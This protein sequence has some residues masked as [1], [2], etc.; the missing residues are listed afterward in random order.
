[1]TKIALA[2][3][4]GDNALDDG[5]ERMIESV[6]DEVQG[7][8]VSF[9]GT[10]MD[11]V[12]EMD[13]I[14]DSHEGFVEAA[15]V[16]VPWTDD[17]SVARNHSFSLVAEAATDFDWILWL[18]CDDV[19]D[20]STY[21][22]NLLDIIE[23]ANEKKLHGVFLD[24]VY[25][26]DAERGVVLASHYKDRLFRADARFEWEYP[27]HENCVGPFSTRMG[28]VFGVRV[29][30]LRGE[31]EP[32]RDRNRRIVKKWYEEA[33]EHEP[34]A[35]MYMGYETFAMAEEAEGERDKELLYASAIK[36]F[37]QFLSMVGAGDDAYAVELM[38]AEA[39]RNLG[40]MNFALDVALQCVKME[41]T[42]NAAYLS[43]AE[44]HITAGNPSEG[45]I[46]ALLAMSAA[47]NDNW[48]EG[49][50][51]AVVPLEAR[52]KPIMT[53]AACEMQLG[54]YEA[55]E[56]WYAEAYEIYPDD[57]TKSKLIEAAGKVREVRNASIKFEEEQPN[58]R[59]SLW[60]TYKNRSIAFFQ[61][62]SIE[63]WDPE[64]LVQEG[65]G[66][67]ET[68]IIKLAQEFARHNW[69]V[70]IFGNPGEN[71]VDKMDEDGI[72]WYNASSF[73]PDEPFTVFV[74]LRNPMPF[75]ANLAAQCKILWL[76]DVTMGDV[77]YQGSRDLFEDIDQIVCVSDFHADHTAAV[78][79]NDVRPKLH[80]IRNSFER[81]LWRGGGEHKILGKM[82][83]ASSP[84]RGLP[85][86][87][88]LWPK[89]AAAVKGASL[90]VFYGWE[91]IDKII[92]S[93]HPTARRLAYFKQRTEA[94]LEALTKAGHTIN[95]HGRQPQKV[96][97]EHL[98]LATVMP[99]PANFME[100]YGI[101]FEQGI[102][103]G[104]IPVVPRLGNLPSLLGPV[105]SR[106]VVQ[107]SPDSMAF[108][109]PFIRAVVE[110]NRADVLRKTDSSYGP[111]WPEAYEQW[112]SMV[113]RH[114]NIND[115]IGVS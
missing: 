104:A 31:V 48:T 8:F 9:N 84:D 63:S 88:E 102:S 81:D 68:C 40:Q 54:N 71:Y 57:F 59:R 34:R 92:E 14:V 36:L 73:H 85:R 75:D 21:E 76:H 22:H 27:I 60:G 42:R 65:L 95:W 51:H 115:P 10:N 91:A 66:G 103:V 12:T 6:K 19:L 99:Y 28:K 46:W 96:L 112:F 2:V 77:R 67:T 113:E 107:G 78:Y 52:Y 53:V 82:V 89:I 79:G 32:K 30:H 25:D 45:K 7:V 80:V 24:Y 41:P 43:I 15:T 16:I 111:E 50:L 61:P 97:A 56:E 70:V 26:Y 114:A 83:Y 37:Q 13:R 23:E 105:Y 35:V 106:Y 90:D 4:A 38:M 86:L 110:A 98:K 20:T 44:T 18:D 87:L 29:L 72:E 47:A 11:V 93:G 74:S 108:E 109:E 55:A 58:V 5:F 33:G 101:V 39:A 69:R 3:I 100:T 64:K 49:S 94:Q 17:F 1:M 62:S